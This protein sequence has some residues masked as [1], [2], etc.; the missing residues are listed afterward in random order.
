M[1]LEVKTFNLIGVD[2]YG[3]RCSLLEYV[4]IMQL[5]SAVKSDWGKLRKAGVLYKLRVR[6]AF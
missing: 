4:P 1:F 2:P 3:A 5:V 6:R